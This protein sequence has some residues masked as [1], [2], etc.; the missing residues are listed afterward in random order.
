MWFLECVQSTC[1]STENRLVYIE[2]VRCKPHGTA[3]Q[4][5]IADKLDIMRMESKKR[6]A[7]YCKGRE[8]EKKGIKRN[9]KITRKQVTQR[10]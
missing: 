4:R 6:K 5:L 10:Q 9:Y 2:T 7:S 1:L 3:K 8:Q